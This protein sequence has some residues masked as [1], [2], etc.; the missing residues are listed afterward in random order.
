MR[1]WTT[2][3][4]GKRWIR[5]ILVL[6][7]VFVGLPL[8]LLLALPYVLSDIDY[9]EMTF[10][11]PT[12]VV[13]KVER[14][15]T[16][17]TVTAKFSVRRGASRGL[18][19]GARGRLFDWPYTLR[20]VADYSIFRLRAD[21]RFDFGLDNTPWRIVGSASRG[22][23]DW[24]AEAELKSAAFDETD[25]VLS[26]LLAKLAPPDVSNLVFSGAVDFRFTGE[27][28]RKLPVPVWS[29]NGRLKD[30]AASGAYKEKPFAVRRL[31]TSF[32][33]EGIADRRTIRPMSP[34]IAYADY[35]GI[36]VTNFSASV[37]MTETALLVTE[38]GAG[39]CGG[40]VKLYSV[41][42]N[43]ERLTA[44][45]TLFL[46]DIDTN[47]IVTHLKG[48]R[49]DATG[50]LHGKI[51]VFLRNGREL[52]LK[53]GYLYSIPGEV[54]TIRF[55]DAAPILDNLA[56]GGVDEATT[57]N[58]AKALANLS[59]T[60]LKFDLKREMDGD[61]LALGMSVEG[62]ATHGETTVPVS[63][64]VTLHGDLEQLINTGLRM[65]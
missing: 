65:K 33:A 10:D 55:E 24:S 27:K 28:T 17:K 22:R 58:L 64:A 49:G 43:P 18:V 56:A 7:F 38:A 50:R 42:L 59:Y 32:G 40:E 34:R 39:F 11:L 60:S 63:F 30:V 15:V 4:L 13:R 19:I 9:P 8:L 16:D 2:R 37:R 25:P 3:I 57:A 14:F 53:N 36:S 46:D 54:G 23:T 41:Y 45:F 1:R 52:R 62:S 5:W 6:A 31:A 47:Q 12:N 20:V 48:F 44:G 61:G 51:P 21:A 29:A 35:N 26:A